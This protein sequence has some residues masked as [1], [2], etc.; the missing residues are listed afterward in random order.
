MKRVAVMRRK[1]QE[2]DRFRLVPGDQLIDI[3]AIAERFGHFFIIDIGPEGGK[4]G[5]KVIVSG[6]P[7]E[8]AKH[9]K[10]Y[11]AKYLKKELR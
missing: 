5:G 7:E 8:V 1:H 3:D 4:G 9:K 11:T 2:S 6:T 10:S